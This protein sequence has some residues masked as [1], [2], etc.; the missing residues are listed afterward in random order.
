MKS[1]PLSKHAI[2]SEARSVDAC[3]CC[4][5][6]GQAGTSPRQDFGDPARAGFSQPLTH[7]PDLSVSMTTGA[8]PLVSVATLHRHGA[9]IGGDKAAVQVGEQREE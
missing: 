6:C 7:T 9:E 3:F 8:A 2:A 1:D 5:L 4:S